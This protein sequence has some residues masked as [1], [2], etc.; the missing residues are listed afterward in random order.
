MS[1]NNDWLEELSNECVAR[2]RADAKKMDK[3]RGA[4][5]N[6]VELTIN[7]NVQDAGVS[8]HDFDKSGT[9]VRL[10]ELHM[11][12]ANPHP[13]YVTKEELRLMFEVVFPV[14]EKK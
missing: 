1:D 14:G 13:Q 12:E 2:I 8:I 4:V 11:D 3:A 6:L 7:G 10:M 5:G 9:A